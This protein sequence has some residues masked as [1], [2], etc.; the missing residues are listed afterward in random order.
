MRSLRSFGRSP[1][2]FALLVFAGLAQ[3]VGAAAHGL[4]LARA[5]MPGMLHEVCTSAGLVR[6]P[7]VPEPTKS[8]WNAGGI[9]DLCATATMASLPAAPANGLAVVLA[10][11]DEPAFAPIL[12]VTSPPQRAYRSRAPPVSFPA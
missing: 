9:C 3:Q 5:G 10:F 4:M 7:G 8:P 2:A 12:L 6:V 11:R 1:L